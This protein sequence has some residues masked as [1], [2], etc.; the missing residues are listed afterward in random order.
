VCGRARCPS[1]FSRSEGVCA[2]PGAA[3]PAAISSGVRTARPTWDEI[4]RRLRDIAARRAG[5]DL[6]EARWLLV[7]RREGLHRHFGYAR[8]EEYMERVLGYGPHAP[9]LLEEAVA[10]IRG[11]GFSAA[12]ARRAVGAAASH[13]GAGASLEALIRAGFQQLHRP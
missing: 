13:A 3:E 2:A 9:T 4:D 8:L 11:T 6:D 7:A 1:R 10:A 12:E 5:L